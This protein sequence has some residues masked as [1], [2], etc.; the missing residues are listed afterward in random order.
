[1]K[2]FTFSQNNS[3]GVFAGPAQYVIVQADD[4]DDAN[5][6]AQD[7][8]VYFDGC[9]TGWD[10]DC[11]GDRWYPYH[12]DVTDSPMIYGTDVADYKPSFGH[13][14]TKL[15]VVIYKNGDTRNFS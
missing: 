7:N 6:I 9:S 3:G 12:S 2:F 14:D 4:A 10:C 8:G 11:C 5:A 15:A 1:M 13:N